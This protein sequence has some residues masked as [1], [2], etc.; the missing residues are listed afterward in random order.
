MAWAG[1]DPDGDGPWQTTLEPTSQVARREGFAAAVNAGFF[2]VGERPTT[3]PDAAA[4]VPGGVPAGVPNYV[5]G[6]PAA[7]VGFHAE[8]GVVQGAPWGAQLVITRG[9]TA[10][11]GRWTVLPGD[12]REAISGSQV[13]LWNGR[14]TPEALADKPRHPRTAAGVADG[15]NTLILLVADGRRP[16]HSDGLTLAELADV[17]RLAGATDALNLDGGGSATMVVPD[18]ADPTR[19]G[20]VAN[21]PSDG[22]LVPGNLVSRERPVADVLG[23]R[24]TAPPATRPAVPAE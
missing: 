17:M 9:D 20:R 6:V 3:R 10:E 23:V 14:T 16:G 21:R 4:G 15:G 7:N 13:V 2:R 19:P 18:P 12:T 11:I 22:S 24:I 8:E 5:E 1:P